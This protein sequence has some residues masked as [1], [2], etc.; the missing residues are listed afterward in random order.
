MGDRFIITGDIGGSSVKMG[1]FKIVQDN[2]QNEEVN[3]DK[4]IELIYKFQIPTVIDI[5]DPKKKLLDDIADSIK[6]LLNKNDYGLNRENLL[7]IG[8]GIPG[9]VLEK[10]VAVQAVNL[11][12]KSPTDLK[13]ELMKRIDEDIVVLATND[14]NAAALGE[15]YYGAGRGKKSLCLITIGT[16]I[17][18]GIIYDGKIVNGK[19]GHAG[20]IGHINVSAGKNAR[21]CECGKKG[22]LEKQSSSRSILEIYE[23]TYSEKIDLPTLCKNAELGEKKAYT[24]LNDAMSKM[25]RVIYSISN[26]L[27]PGIFLIGGG[28]THNG[29]IV[30]DLLRKN[31]AKKIL[32]FDPPIDIEYAT[33]KN[34]AGIWGLA[35]YVKDNTL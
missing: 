27:N 9:P 22:C 32:S 17:G 35:K 7:G 21:L 13:E 12:W 20:E 19:D 3:E 1:L 2:S 18:C 16:G 6:N 11:G 29:P 30:L 5:S 34:D 14:A 8:L 10:E 31:V 15:C 26:I 33:L 23:S 4:D 24:I 25:S 28:I